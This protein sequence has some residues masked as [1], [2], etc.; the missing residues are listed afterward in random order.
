MR[1]GILLAFNQMNRYLN[2]TDF[3]WMVLHFYCNPQSVLHN[4][5]TCTGSCYKNF[6]SHTLYSL[7][8]SCIHVGGSRLLLSCS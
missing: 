6:V 4:Y 7:D 5:S 2:S 8:R 1:S 3:L